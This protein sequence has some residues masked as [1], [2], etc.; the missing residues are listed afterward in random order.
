MEEIGA[1][2]T[3]VDTKVRPRN[4]PKL[5]NVRKEHTKLME[6]C[7]AFGEKVNNM[8][9]KQRGEYMHA[10]EQH[11]YDVQKQLHLLR[12]KVTEIAN[13]KTRDEKIQQLSADQIKYRHEALFFDEAAADLRKKIKRLKE[14][15]SSV[16]KSWLSIAWMLSTIF[17]SSFF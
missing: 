1:F 16:G 15:M 7:A 5:A 10:Y 4:N 2:L 8:V 6:V 14:T 9:D 12:E 11:M 17:S 3:E 13:D